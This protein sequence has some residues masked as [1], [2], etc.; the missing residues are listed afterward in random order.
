L[1]S[2]FRYIRFKR[3][4][5]IDFGVLARILKESERTMEPLKNP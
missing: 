3:A 4:E 1:D 5:N 2:D